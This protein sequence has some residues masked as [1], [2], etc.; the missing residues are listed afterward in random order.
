[1][2]DLFDC[3]LFTLS[4]PEKGSS[5]G[6]IRF[7]VRSA[8]P[9]DVELVA[10]CANVTASL[11]F[12]RMQAQ[13]TNIIISLDKESSRIDVLSRLEDDGVELLW[14]P[15]QMEPRQ[16]DEIRERIRSKT[17]LLENKMMEPR[18]T[19]KAAPFDEPASASSIGHS[20]NH[21][22]EHPAEHGPD[23]AITPEQ[24]AEEDY[25]IKQLHRIP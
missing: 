16:L 20:I 2:S 9:E 23:A 18:S 17:F 12:E 1:M 5:K 14:P 25:Q 6:H 24:E 21:P 10:F 19:P 13:G 3:P 7:S 8:R 4:V 11:L 15:K 22:I